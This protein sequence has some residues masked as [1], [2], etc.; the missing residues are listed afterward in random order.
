MSKGQIS[1]DNRIYWNNKIE[2]KFDE[3][4]EAVES[5]FLDEITQNAERQYP[6]FLK[7][8]GI[9]KDLLLIEEA[10][11]AYN[12]FVLNKQKTENKLWIKLC[13]AYTALEK[14]WGRWSQ[15][16]KWEA[17]I[18]E[19][20]KAKDNVLVEEIHSN[21]KDNCYQEVKK[22]FYKSSKSK[23]LQKIEAW[24]EQAKDVLHSDMIGSEVL[25][26]L[27]NICKQSNI[28]ISIPTEKN[29]LKIT[30][31]GE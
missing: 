28:A 9:G 13:G 21:L 6:K 12:D 24:R 1:K 8:L 20:D 11:R 15:S 25:K 10:Q 19:I 17:S 31:G 16:R 14:K 7:V 29:T 27:Q 18:P 3:K 22:S 23:E 2:G 30:N 26:T 5:M 4:K